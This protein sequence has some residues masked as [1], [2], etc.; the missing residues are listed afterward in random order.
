MF[1]L[2]NDNCLF[3]SEGPLAQTGAPYARVPGI[4]V[5]GMICLKKP[6]RRRGRVMNGFQECNKIINIWVTCRTQGKG[7]VILT[8]NSNG[9]FPHN[10]LPFSSPSYPPLFS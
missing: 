3:I 7:N 9:K 1:Q 4:R 8:N 2:R 10:L 6:F 5:Y